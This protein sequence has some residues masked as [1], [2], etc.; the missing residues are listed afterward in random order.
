MEISA[1]NVKEI[2]TQ[3]LAAELIAKLEPEQIEAMITAQIKEALT[4]YS[5]RS[6]VYVVVAEVASQMAK[7]LLMTK[8]VRDE[9]T[10]QVRKTIASKIEAIPDKM[11]LGF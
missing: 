1:E 6:A 4:S 5:T 2:A 10:L 3:R 11:E 7:E 8:E 9:L